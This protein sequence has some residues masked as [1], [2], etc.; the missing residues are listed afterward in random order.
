MNKSSADTNSRSVP[1]SIS[2]SNASLRKLGVR[3]AVLCF[4]ILLLAVLNGR[5]APS[6]NVPTPALPDYG[7]RSEAG[8]ETATNALPQLSG[9]P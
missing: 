9:R 6:Q 4:L 1:D 7:A 8:I 3:I 2:L 5:A